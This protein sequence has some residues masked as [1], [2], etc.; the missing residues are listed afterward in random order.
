MRTGVIFPLSPGVCPRSSVPG[1]GPFQSLEE[2]ELN[3][4]GDVWGIG[5]GKGP[6]HARRSRWL[7]FDLASGNHPRSQQVRSFAEKTSQGLLD[8]RSTW[9]QTGYA[10]DTWIPGVRDPQPPS[11]TWWPASLS[12]CRESQSPKGA[13]WERRFISC[14]S[15]VAPGDPGIHRAQLKAG[16]WLVPPFFHK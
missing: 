4:P 12:R 6:G 3:Q 10:A 8:L 13:K 7:I 14:F 15:R 1:Q 16:L 11:A 9:I 5:G 2:Y